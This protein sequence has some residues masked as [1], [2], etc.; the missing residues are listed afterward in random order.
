MS[1]ATAPTVPY[2]WVLAVGSAELEEDEVAGVSFDSAES[3]T[4]L[5]GIETLDSDS[6]AYIKMKKD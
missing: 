4:V 5:D 3:S 1:L 2:L 6:E